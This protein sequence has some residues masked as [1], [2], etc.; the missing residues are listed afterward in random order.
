MMIRRRWDEYNISKVIG[1][2][3][4]CSNKCAF[5]ACVECAVMTGMFITHNILLLLIFKL[6]LPMTI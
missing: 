1:N 2:C 4:V 6:I 5:E 3:W